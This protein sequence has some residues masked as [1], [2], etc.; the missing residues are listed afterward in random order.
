MTYLDSAEIAHVEDFAD[1]ISASPSSYH[2]AAEIAR[3]LEAVGFTQVSESD[4]MSA[5]PGGRFFIRDGAVMTWFVPEDASAA[6]FRIVGCHTDSPGLKIK[7]SGSSTTSDG[8]GQIDVELYGGLLLN[9]WLDREVGFAGRLIDREGNEHL[10]NT[11]PIARIPQLAIHLDREINKDGLK[12]DRQK[13]MQ[14]VWMLGDGQTIFDHLAQLAGLDSADQIAGHDLV[15]Y[16]T[17]KPARFGVNEEFFAAGRQDNLSSV[18]AGL[19]AM[20]KLAGREDGLA[21]T[22]D[23]AVFA[24]FD[25]EEVGS[26]TRSG[27]SGPI[28]ESVLRRLAA[29]TGRDEDGYHRMLATTTCVSADAGHFVHPNYSERHDPNNH[30]MPGAGPMLKLNA[31]QRYAT[32]AVGTALWNRI[33]EAAGVE[34]QA[35]VSNNSVPCGS[36]IGPLTATRLGITTVDV[37]IG[38][39]SMHSAREMSHVKDHLALSRVIEQYWQGA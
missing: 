38:L 7:P 31:N 19:V 20:E 14:P 9:S 28:L 25:H 21:N 23:I 5:E 37:G 15:S 33:C 39:L 35:F 30:P 12:L 34:N 26:S 8:W 27:A 11:G 22:R 4:P 13:H 16:A 10:V 29:A 1:F 17:E 24:A 2:A 18:H 36:T 32:D 3:R 6:S